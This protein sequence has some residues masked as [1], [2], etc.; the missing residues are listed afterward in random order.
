MCKQF[1]AVHKS[2]V[3][4]LR[5][6]VPSPHCIDE[7]TEAQRGKGTSP[8]VLGPLS[9]ECK[10]TYAIGFEKSCANRIALDLAGWASLL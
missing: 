2:H 5:K 8:I 9:K 4:L 10:F 7:K 3:E 6:I 1:F